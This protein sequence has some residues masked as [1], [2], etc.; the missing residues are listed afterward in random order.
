[1]VRLWQSLSGESW[2]RLLS[3]STSWQIQ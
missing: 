3:A 2:I 1:L